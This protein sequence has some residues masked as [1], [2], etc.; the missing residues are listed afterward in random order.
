MTIWGFCR[1]KVVERNSAGQDVDSVL[2]GQAMAVPSHLF[3]WGSQAL[4]CVYSPPRHYLE[5]DFLYMDHSF[6]FKTESAPQRSYQRVPQR[7]LQRI[8]GLMTFRYTPISL[9]IWVWFE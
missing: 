5:N 9:I 4:C 6:L 1:N 7:D 3:S 8:S 2:P